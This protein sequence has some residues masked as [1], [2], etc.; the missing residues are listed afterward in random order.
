[1]A[2]GEPLEVCTDYPE[3]YR[4]PGM[5]RFAPWSRQVHYTAHYT[6]E[7]G[8]ERSTQFTDMCRRVGLRGAVPLT[9]AWEVKNPTIVQQ[10][11]DAAAG[12]PILFVHGGRE[13]FGRSDGFGLSLLPDANVF[14]AVLAEIRQKYFAIYCGRGSRLFPVDVDLDLNDQ[15]CVTDMI[16]LAYAAADRFY[17]QASF[18]LPLAESF[19]KKVLLCFSAKGFTSRHQAVRTITPKKLLHKKTS[20]YF[21]DNWP[22]ERIAE[23]V[24]QFCHP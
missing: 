10:V 19:D 8:D 12:R 5:V 21:V 14:N 2:R 4:F 18:A 23:A 9:L 20:T 24:G 17:A 15:T 16:D 11:K 1:M 7:K 6:K 3:L 22:R 13:A